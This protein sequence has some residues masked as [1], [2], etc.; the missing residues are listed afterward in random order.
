MGTR[1]ELHLGDP[2]ESEIGMRL[3]ANVPSVPGRGLTREAFHFLTALPRIDGQANDDELTQSLRELGARMTSAWPGSVAPPVRLLPAVLD[4]AQLP[5]AEGDIRV[6]LG[7]DEL[8]LAPVWHDFA[9]NPHLMLFG[10]TE[11]GKTS[12]LRLIAKAIVNRYSPDEARII[13]ADYRRDLYDA[14]PASHQLG[15][16]TSGSSLEQL[17]N[18]SMEPLRARVPGPDIS[19]EQLRRRDWWTGPKLFVLV[20]DYDLVN[21]SMTNPLQTLMELV[22]QGAEIGLHLVL[23]RATAGISR[24]MLMD[25][26]LRR[27]WDISTPA[28]LFSCSKEEGQFLGD[29]RPRKLP[30]GRAMLVTRRNAPLLMQTAYYPADEQIPQ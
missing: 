3:A 18:D 5:P 19:P 2:V 25:H 6:P 13:M 26:V 21:S 23:A 10:D 14:V 12:T 22:P 27:L 8:Q 16:A 11:T 15:Y 7:L 4:P 24:S 29:V 30:S 9:T 1:F 28:L 20:D 17:I